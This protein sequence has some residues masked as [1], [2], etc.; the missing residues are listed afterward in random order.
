MLFYKKPNRKNKF[1]SKEDL[2]YRLGAA[3]YMPATRDDISHIIA[4]KKYE[5]IRTYVICLE[6]AIS[7]D[8]VEKAEASLIFQF[9]KLKEMIEKN[10]MNKEELPFIFIRP[11]SADY[12]KRLLPKIRE[13]RDLFFGFVLPKFEE[14]NALKYLELLKDEVK[15]L[16]KPYYIM[17]IIE[18]ECFIYK[19]T[20]F[21]SFE[22]INEILKPYKDW[23]L[24]I[25][26]GATDLSSHY[27]LR[28]GRD[29]S[30]YD[31]G[32]VGECICDIVNYFS[33]RGN[34]YVISG[35][36]WEYFD[37]DERLLKPQLR[38]TPFN[39]MN[40][41]SGLELRRKYI[42]K[43]IDSLIREV[44]LDKNNGMIGKTIIHP[45][46]GIIINALYSVSKEDY[47]DALSI[48]EIEDKGGVIRSSYL[49][50]MNEVGPH[51]NWAK[52]IM[53][54]ADAYGVLNDHVDQIAYIVNLVESSNVKI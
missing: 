20:R 32:I 43:N 52:K 39:E 18:S 17:P 24:N 51:A 8:E 49:N 11:R 21:K 2:E 19:E 10:E 22:Y 48:L 41:E 33:R 9:K 50:K 13:Y 5:F 27:G 35:P 44:I 4:S 47:M 3:L 40:I 25:R 15:Y 28:R 42:R 54:R 34:D 6:D 29:V 53:K 14:K 23:V 7:S 12:L 16:E 46:H 45:S 37:N 26:I 1:S 36:V 30:V 38:E 31:I